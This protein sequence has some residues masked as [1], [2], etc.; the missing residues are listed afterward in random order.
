M[1]NKLTKEEIEE[2]IKDFFYGKDQP[3]FTPFMTNHKWTDEEGNK[4]SASNLGD[5]LTT[6]D[7]GA[8]MIHKAMQEA[9]KNL[10]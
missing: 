3:A 1:E 6:G 9:V 7:G 5:R 2:T 10:K 8:E 4:Y